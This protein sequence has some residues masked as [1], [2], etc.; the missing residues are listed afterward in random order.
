MSA[1]KKQV[2]VEIL[3]TLNEEPKLNFFSWEVAVRNAAAA[4][5]KP[6]T[7]RGLLSPVLTDP[8]LNAYPANISVDAQ[9]QQVIA[10]RYNPPAYVEI[11]NNMN[12]VK[13]IVIKSTNDQLLEWITGEEALKTAIVKSLGPIVQQIIGHPEDGFT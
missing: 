2:H 1:S 12:G 13:V 5:C 3:T 6:I 10:P 9:G 4:I 8:Q 7:P 11:N